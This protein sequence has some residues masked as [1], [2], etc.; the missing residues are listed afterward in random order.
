VL[1]QNT[2]YSE[3]KHR[4]KWKIRGEGAASARGPQQV[5][6][7]HRA[8]LSNLRCGNAGCQEL[9][10]QELRSLV[11]SGTLTTG[12]KQSQDYR[13]T[14]DGKLKSSYRTFFAS[15]ALPMALYKYDYDMI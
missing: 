1:A 4:L 3:K 6:V 12:G 8:F 11:S 7:R 2:R 15:V 5:V 13:C 10:V 9:E 14:N